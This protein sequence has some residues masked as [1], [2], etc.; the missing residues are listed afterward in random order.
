MML[1]KEHGLKLN[2]A[3]TDYYGVVVKP[4]C[5][6]Y[7]HEVALSVQSKEFKPN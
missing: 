1:I 2:E 6:D 3:F 5:G 4:I 7:L